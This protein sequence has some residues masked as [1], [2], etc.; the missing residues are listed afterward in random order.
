MN[1]KSSLN[2]MWVTHGGMVCK[3][4][5][6]ITVYFIL[7]INRLSAKS[8]YLLLTF[9][10]LIF[11]VYAML[12]LHTDTFCQLPIPSNRA[13]SQAWKTWRFDVYL[14]RSRIA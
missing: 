9:D 2:N 13:P 4:Y 3:K 12:M 7:L 11:C 5:V 14:S 1:L 8:R 6:I 10:S